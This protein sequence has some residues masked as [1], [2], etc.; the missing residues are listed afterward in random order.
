VE[1]VTYFALLSYTSA[2][3]ENILVELTRLVTLQTPLPA[4]KLVNYVHVIIG[5]ATEFLKLVPQPLCAGHGFLKSI[6][7]E[8]KTDI[9]TLEA[10]HLELTLK[11]IIRSESHL[12]TQA[13][14]RRTGCGLHV[15]IQCVGVTRCS[16]TGRYLIALINRTL[17]VSL[18]LAFPNRTRSGF[19][20]VH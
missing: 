1:Y 13:S 6:R 16:H 3:T 2:L 17:S 14:T 4:M 19:G 5:P 18:D 20:R 7:G 11:G 8:K 12:G 9:V 15:L 10:R